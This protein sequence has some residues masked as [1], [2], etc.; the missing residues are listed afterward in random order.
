M[1][2]LSVSFLLLFIISNY[3]YA[4]NDNIGQIHGN[5][6]IE[7]QYYQ[8]DTL[9]G[10]QALP[11][12]FGINSYSNF[13]YTKEKFSAGVRYEGYFP[14]L[15]GYDQRYKGAGI[16][17]KYA[18]YN[19]DIIEITAGNFYEQYGSG[20]VLRAYEEKNLGYDNTFEGIRIKF[21][22][23]QGI[24]FKCLIGRQRNFWN[25][26]GL[27]RGI[28]AELNANELIGKLKESKMQIGLGG[29]FVSKYQ[30][31]QDAVYKYPENVAAGAGRMNIS[32][33]KLNFS[34]E[35]VYKANDPSFDNGKIYKHGE[36]LLINA[37]YSQKGLGIFF[38]AKRIDNM[39]FRSDRSASLSELSINY[40]P[41]IT[42]PHTYSMPAMYPYV[43]Q[44]TSEM[45]MQTEI[46]YTIKKESKIGGKYG[47]NI[48]LN[49][50][51]A[52]NI[53]KSPPSD[54]SII[55]VDGTLGYKSD[56]FALGDEFYFQDFNIQIN[57]KISPDFKTTFM[58]Q[59]LTYN[60]DIIHGANNKLTHG[61]IYTNA[62]VA[63]MTYKIIKNTA[64]RVELE[65]LFTEQDYGNWAMAVVE[66]SIPHFFFTIIDQ[67]N[68]GNPD[69]NLRVHYYSC[70][71]G[72]NKGAHRFEVGYGKKRAGVICVGG[73]CRAV[74]AS[75][76]FTL[77]I[78]SSF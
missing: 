38:A 16:P 57:R 42:K 46:I 52:N 36:A 18:S 45:G 64:M 68:F 67:Y 23:Y 60:Q 71:I 15:N 25:Y 8:D 40:I 44:I 12:H 31:D 28:D 13:N 72:F 47:T 27:V 2:N 77:S 30:T 6:Q 32:Y 55:G 22:P 17:F 3:L 70:A 48:S 41:D 61:M 14:P 76:G 26:S 21:N 78:T 20:L 4:Q 9:I 54:T 35:Y 10:A 24:Y 39:S 43:T 7:A 63:D 5:F 53:Q 1:K 75:N 69:N 33:G 73:I 11:E 66:L 62:F 50:S 65:S 56:F 59:N 29:S 19:A 49:Y 51:V 74:P 34:T 58:Y 37:T